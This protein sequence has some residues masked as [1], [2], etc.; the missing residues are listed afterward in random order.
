MRE[1]ENVNEQESY[2]EPIGDNP[3]GRE[4]FIKKIVGGGCGCLVAAGIILT[5]A[6]AAVGISS[7]G[8]I[9]DSKESI[10]VSGYLGNKNAVSLSLTPYVINNLNRDQIIRLSGRATFFNFDSFAN[11]S[12]GYESNTPL[13]DFNVHLSSSP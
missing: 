10:L 7:V 1:E 2:I 4:R 11:L 6:G 8:R 12:V 5:L 3:R 9:P 13:F